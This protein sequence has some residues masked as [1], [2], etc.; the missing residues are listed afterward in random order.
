M[1]AAPGEGRTGFMVSG[2]RWGAFGWL[3]APRQQPLPAPGPAPPAP[4]HS[5]FCPGS[6]LLGDTPRPRSAS[7]RRLKP[8]GVGL[9][10]FL[11]TENPGGCWGGLNATP[12]R[13]APHLAA[14]DERV[15]PSAFEAF[16]VASSLPRA[17]SSR[18]RLRPTFRR[19][20]SSPKTFKPR[21]C[22]FLY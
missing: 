19:Q 14:G 8:R 3:P 12:P 13:R 16:R 6:S 1:G 9:G 10:V 4:P 21:L 11:L 5:R 7:R 22:S 2:A 17:A 15:P 18:R 20:T